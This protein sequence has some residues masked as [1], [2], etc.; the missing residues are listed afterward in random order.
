LGL[1]ARS[2][3]RNGPR[4][5]CFAASASDGAQMHAAPQRR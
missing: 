1:P 2:P 5:C 3:A 4:C